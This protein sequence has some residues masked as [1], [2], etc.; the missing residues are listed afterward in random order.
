MSALVFAQRK[1][2]VAGTDSIHVKG[3][4]FLVLSDTSIYVKRDTIFYLPDSVVA[5]LK[6][7]R[8]GRSAEFYKKLKEKLSKRKVTK[9]LYDL[10]FNDTSKPKSSIKSFDGPT[11][12]FE[13]YNGRVINKIQIKRLDP[14]GTKV[15]DTTSSA[16]DTFSKLGNRTHATTREFV[17]RNNLLIKEGDEVDEEILRDTERILRRLP[18]LRDAR[19]Y[20][21]PIKGTF[22][23]D[24]LVITKDVWNITGSA[25]YS[26]PENFDFT[27]TD[28]NFLGLG[29]E[30]EN[31]FP[32]TTDGKPNLG[33]LGTYRAN[34][35]KGTFITGE[36]TLGRSFEFDRRGIEFFRNFITPETKHAGGIEIAQER[37]LNARIFIDT[38]IVFNTRLSFQ[39]YWYGRSFLIHE[40]EDGSRTNFQV[41]GA[42]VVNDFIERP[43]TTPDTN[44]VFVD[45]YTRLLSVGIARRKFDRSSLI[46]GFGRTEDIPLGYLAELTLGRENNTFTTRTYFGSQ[47]AYGEYFDRVGFIRPSI[48]FGSF[49]E[50]EELEQGV[51]K[52]QV[53]YFSFL[54]R[55]RRTNLRQFFRFK[56]TYGI[57]R[58][59]TEFIDINDE[60]GV[61][62]LGDVT[63][64]GTKKI[65][66]QMETVAFTPI[67]FAGFRMAVFGF[68][69]FA[70]V[71]NTKERLF[72]NTLYQGY[73]VGLRFRN[74][75]LA[76][77]TFQIRFGWY[78]NTPAY[79]ANYDFDF[80]GSRNLELNGFRVNRPEVITFD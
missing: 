6:K 76:F 50:N 12:D 60:R 61:R 47:L 43:I 66:F 62:G 69:D 52:V 67:Y 28:R 80:S 59:S 77:N 71:D 33:Y 13:L 1:G 29:Y 56:Y 31:E 20:I 2:K 34:N 11:D 10:F 48:T 65:S 53:D 5:K 63:L 57:N 35:I 26:D 32:Y 3:K 75:N 38:T 21:V 68:L 7:D 54:Y 55:I 72:D 78:P 16:K 27:I 8:E 18:F 40:D 51:L 73:G 19:V 22:Q 15:T 41:A 39:D 36:L 25:S 4:S 23:V 17:V 45:S 30:F 9:E 44:Q 24:I 46:L 14:F 74:E 64:R 79:V 70:M 42:Y 37:R 49:I 58:F